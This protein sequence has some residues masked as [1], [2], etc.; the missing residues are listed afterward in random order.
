M[1][2]PN[3]LQ[4][5]RREFSQAAAGA[6]GLSALAGVG[7][8]DE[9]DAAPI[10]GKARACIFLWLGGGMCHVDTF[11]P[12]P[13]GDPSGKKAGSAYPAI[14]TA[15]HGVQVCEHLKRTAGVMDRAVLLRSV[16]HPLSSEHAAPTNLFKTGRPTS[17]TIVYP[18][19]GSIVSHELGPQAE[20]VPAYVVMGYPNV[21][22]GPGF[23]GAKYSYLYLTDT[24]SGPNGLKRPPD[25]D[26][27]RLERRLAVL[28]T[29]RS[30]FRAKVGDD[31]K[32]RDYDETISEALRLAG[33]QFS[34]VFELDREPAEVR[35]R[36]GGEFGQ[37]CLLARRLVEAGV[38][39]IEVS[40]NLN[41]LNGTGWDTH[42]HGQKDQHRL[43]QD[44][45][46][47]LAA[48]IEDLERRRLFDSTLV[49]LATEFGRP[50]E[51]DGGGGRGHQS[52]AFSTVLFGGGLKL[53]QAIGATDEFG[54]KVT[55][56]PISLPDWHAT[57]HTALGIDP[58]KELYAGER[59][60]PITDHGRPIREA[61]A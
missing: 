11:D 9:K 28:S 37:R 58:A 8:A 56:R 24:A 12:K 21:T 22:R 48:L 14:A 31:A 4:L 1:A 30:R 54:R 3:V 25:V 43:I 19:I 52:A 44:L 27:K 47:S 20:G 5:N 57:I 51:F 35:N 38:R 42:R 13:L 50:P 6:A 10:G 33:P 17:G 49:V 7:L 45:D 55:E 41:F 15:I 40:F 46:Q 16:T 59:P 60:V 32:V 61:F 29:L 18:S 53:G 26:D 39:F 34:S 36:Y 2:A 23:L